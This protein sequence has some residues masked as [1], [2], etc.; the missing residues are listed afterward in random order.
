LQWYLNVPVLLNVKLKVL[1]LSKLPLSK[2]LPESAVTV[3]VIESLLVH[4]TVVPFLTVMLAGEKL[5]LVML[6]LSV[7][8]AVLEF[9]DEE[10]LSEPITALLLDVLVLVEG[11]ADGVG[12]L[13]LFLLAATMPTIAAITIIT[14]AIGTNFL[15]LN[16][17]TT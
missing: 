5:E 14:T 15:I 8:V 9:D 16:L 10:S 4:V 1:L 11:F 12:A 6:T 17:L 7:L 3:W 2:V 13:L